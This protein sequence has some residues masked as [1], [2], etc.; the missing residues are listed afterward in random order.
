MA[1]VVIQDI[2]YQNLPLI[3]VPDSQSGENVFFYDTSNANIVAADIRNG[4]IGF[5]EQGEVVGSM[6]EK[7]AAT[8]SPSTSNQTISANQYLT[9]NQV[10]EAVTTTNLTASNI[11]YGVTVKVGS[12]SD[13][14]CVKSVEGNIRVPVI[15]QDSVTKI[16]YIS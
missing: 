16:L 1:S 8:Y 14:D 11:L 15:R 5:S 7:S 12:A 13:D 10:I 6:T 3:A 4:K 9:G 2:V